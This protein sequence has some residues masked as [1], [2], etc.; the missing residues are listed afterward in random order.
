[1]PVMLPPFPDIELA[2][3]DWFPQQTWWPA[4]ARVVTRT[5]TELETQLPVVQVTRVGGASDRLHDRP[6]VDVNVFAAT[7]D[8][9]QTLAQTIRDA[10]VPGPVRT[11]RGLLDRVRCEV[12]P[13]RVPYANPNVWYVTAAY[14][15]VCRRTTPARPTP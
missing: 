7:E 5:P 15:F 6:R 2:L 10:L 14:Q 3:H 9:A 1:M 13:N 11:P 8:D 12:G 4:A